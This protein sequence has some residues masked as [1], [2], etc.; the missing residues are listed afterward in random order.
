MTKYVQLA[1]VTVNSLLFVH[2]LDARAGVMTLETPME[3]HP[4]LDARH[5]SEHF[6]P[7]STDLALA[8]ARWYRSVRRNEMRR[9]LGQKKFPEKT[10]SRQEILN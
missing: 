1:S 8:G 7:E 5:R 3:V 4:Y 10:S 9:S 6:E 2:L